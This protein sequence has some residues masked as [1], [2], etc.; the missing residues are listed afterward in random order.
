MGIPWKYACFQRLNISFLKSTTM[1]PLWSWYYQNNGLQ[2]P[3]TFPGKHTNIQTMNEIR[4]WVKC[5]YI[6]RYAADEED[7]I[8]LSRSLLWII[9]ET[10]LQISRT[11]FIIHRHNSLKQDYAG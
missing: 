7:K 11:F 10:H 4:N 3:Q 8:T 6:R 2:N 5:K 1:K 9:L